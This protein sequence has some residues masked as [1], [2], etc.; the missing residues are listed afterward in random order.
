LRFNVNYISSRPIAFMNDQKIPAYWLG[1]L[2]LAYS[3][4]KIGFAQNIKTNFGVTNLFSKNYIGG[5]TGS[6]GIGG[7]D[8]CNLFI[9]APR[10]FYGT[11][12]ADF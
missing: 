2:G 8:N 5:I 10:E 3:F 9:A 11:V 7:D 6:A 12:S 1:T 4:G